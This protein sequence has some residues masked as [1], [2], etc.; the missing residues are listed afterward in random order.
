[1]G[2]AR[3]R[4]DRGRRRSC[5][6]PGRDW[7][8]AV[9][10]VNGRVLLTHMGKYQA[11]VAVEGDPRRRCAA[12]VADG[13]TSP[14]VVFTEPQVAAVGLT[15]AGGARAGP[16]RHQGSRSRLGGDRRGRASTATTRPGTSCLVI[17]DDRHVL[18]GATFA[19]PDVAEWLHAATIAGG[20]RGARRAPAPRGALLSRRAARC[21]CACLGCTSARCARA[22]RASAR[23]RRSSARRAQ[24]ARCR[25][26]RARSRGCRRR[27]GCSSV[28]CR[29]AA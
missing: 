5:A 14:R 1:M 10:D 25:R 6:C 4:A 21:G 3:G 15:D 28:R 23:A 7:L 27:S 2:R 17:D 11:A 8:Y 18:V 26:P 22:R 24:R 29:W 12:C 16:A 19:G 20:G 9:G 13:R